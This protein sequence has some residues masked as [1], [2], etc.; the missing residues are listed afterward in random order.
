MSKKQDALSCQNMSCIAMHS[1]NPK[2]KFHDAKAEESLQ[3]VL[4]LMS[5]CHRSA[6]LLTMQ[7]MELSVLSA[8]IPEA[9]QCNENK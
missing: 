6:L 5:C 8:F 3:G 7:R 9:I 2:N 1:R 4:C